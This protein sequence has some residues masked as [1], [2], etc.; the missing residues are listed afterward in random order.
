MKVRVETRGWGGGEAKER[1]MKKE[2]Q[3]MGVIYERTEEL[4]SMG[5]GPL[6]SRTGDDG[7][8]FGIWYL[9]ILVVLVFRI[10]V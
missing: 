4:W 8:M 2:K 9:G 3:W 5:P 7:L 10:Q 1:N 6:G